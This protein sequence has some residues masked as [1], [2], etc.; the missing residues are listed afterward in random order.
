MV[1]RAMFLPMAFANHAA[2]LLNY[3]QSPERD[4]DRMNNRV[5]RIGRVGER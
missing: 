1:L 4:G 5:C 3:L 2:R